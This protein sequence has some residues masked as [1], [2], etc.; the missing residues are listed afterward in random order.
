MSKEQNDKK[1]KEKLKIAKSETS[2]KMINY[3]KNVFVYIS[4]LHLNVL[5][6][7][8]VHSL[9]WSLKILCHGGNNFPRFS[10]IFLIV[11]LLTWRISLQWW[12]ETSVASVTWSK[13]CPAVYHLSFDLLIMD[14]NMLKFL[15]FMQ[16][17]LS[18]F[19]LWQFSCLALKWLI[20]FE[21]VAHIFVSIFSTLISLEII[22]HRW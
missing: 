7:L 17:I 18:F 16:S 5:N 22:P 9:N 8:D 10:T 21:V 6:I 15:T 20:N 13:D 19:P 3:S 14:I 2:K 4:Y 11:A 1:D 12:L